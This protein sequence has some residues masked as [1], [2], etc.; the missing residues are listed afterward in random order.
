MDFERPPKIWSPGGRERSLKIP[1]FRVSL[2]PTVP[3]LGPALWLYS[4]GVNP[5]RPSARTAA[6]HMSGSQAP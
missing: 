6:A 4:K 1:R 5:S 2:G 3:V